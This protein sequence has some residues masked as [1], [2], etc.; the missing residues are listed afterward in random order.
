[1]KVYEAV[2]RACAAEV[3]PGGTVFALMGDA[4]MELLASLEALG[5]VALVHARHENAAVAMADG[6]G[7]ATGAPGVC[8][9]TCGPGLTQIGTSLVAAARHHTPLVVLAGDTPVEADFHLQAFGQERFVLACEAEFVRLRSPATAAEDVRRAF[10]LARTKRR[11]VVLSL[12]MD[13]QDAT[14]PWD[15]AYDG[16]AGLVPEAPPAA[17][18]DAD[19]APLVA[20]LQSAARPIVLAGRG[21]VRA[22]AT[23][24]LADVADRCG[25]LLATTLRAKGCFE[26]S[27]W[28][29]GVAGAF[30]TAAA[31]EL[32]AE[33]DVVLAVGAALGYYTTEGGYLFP[34]ATVVQVDT[35]PVGLH[36]GLPV[37]AMYVRGDA[38]AVADAL[39]RL[40]PTDSPTGYR[41]APLAPHVR[42]DPPA[43][44]A[45]GGGLHPAA[46]VHA[47]SASL[48]P[49]TM[50]VVGAGHFWNFVVN[51]L[52][53]RDP[54]ATIYTYDFGVIGQGVPVAMGAASARGATVVIEGDG[55]L[56]MNAQ[57]LETIARHGVPVLCVVMNDGA[58]G[59]EVHKLRAKGFP[60]EQVL[61]GRTDLA[62]VAA[63]FGVPS[64]VVTSVDQ[65]PAIVQRFLA[66][67][68]PMVADVHISPEVIAPQYR[69]LFF[70]E[71]G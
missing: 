44:E 33:A 31:R 66:D 43:T 35:E 60:G 55:S 6:Y 37:G 3:G 34:N 26:T 7:R 20:A 8:T 54:A 14:Y 58:Y 62:A 67:P 12:P 57:E 28:N 13:V 36:E 47:L 71:A 46:V 18:S 4:N 70:G 53:G 19:L 68:R 29:V 27:E 45:V 51:G 21:A 24:A 10:F 16:S 15:W 25:A 32:F 9:I 39:V 65:L 50:L 56:I 69:R 61:F 5:Q 63:A 59:A 64:C 2:A 40:L 22:G 48:P 11:P 17:P 23:G 30:S 42:L 49:D 38:K 52:A 1:M 41:T